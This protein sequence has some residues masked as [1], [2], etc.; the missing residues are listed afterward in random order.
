VIIKSNYVH[1][2]R[3]LIEPPSV[4]LSVATST[5]DAKVVIG[6]ALT[7]EPENED[8]LRHTINVFLQ[9]FRECQFFTGDLDE[10]I[11]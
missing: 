3:T 8:S 4:E 6:P 9:M 1:A 10:I 5:S 7:Y 2:L 11:R